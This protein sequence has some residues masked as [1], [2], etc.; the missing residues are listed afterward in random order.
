MPSRADYL[1][2]DIVM[3]RADAI[4]AAH[5]DID[6]FFRVDEGRWLAACDH[7]RAT[8]EALYSDD[9]YQIEH[10]LQRGI[11][12]AIEPAIVFLEADPWCFRSGY[13]KQRLL[14]FLSRMDLSESD[15]ARLRRWLLSALPKGWRREY[16][17]M[18]RLA[19]RLASPEFSASLRNV[20]ADLSES[21]RRSIAR[22]AD[23]VDAAQAHPVEQLSSEGAP[24]EMRVQ[25]P[26]PIAPR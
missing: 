24:G 1:E 4:T 11:P 21:A 22:V 7:A 8:L 6:R 10:D 16:K 25:D 17:L 18:I 23:A 5:A 15:K 26:P 2:H 13:A 19:M 12:A 3:A 20:A 14:R 9:W